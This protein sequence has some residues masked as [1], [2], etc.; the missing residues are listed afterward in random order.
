MKRTNI[1]SLLRIRKK[2]KR[3]KPE[4]LRVYWYKKIR[5]KNRKDSWRRPKGIHNKIRKKI[6]GK[7]EMVE[8]GYGSP[9]EVKGLLRNG[10][11]PVLV[12]NIEELEK[13]DKEKEIAVIASTVGRRKREQIIKR[14]KEL[15]IEIYNP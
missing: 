7:P 13:I 9:R 5:L 15:N 2:I 3:K 11:R 1:F 8:V 10:K 14:A 6:K 12:H 4:Y